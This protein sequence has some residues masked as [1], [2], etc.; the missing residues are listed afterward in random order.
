MIIKNMESYKKVK[1]IFID[2][3]VPKEERDLYPIVVDN[4]P[5][6]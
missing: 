5:L 2:E 4:K 6:Q 3:K 1:D